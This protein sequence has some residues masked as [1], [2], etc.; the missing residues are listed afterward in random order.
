MKRFIKNT[1]HG[2]LHFGSLGGR[3]SRQTFCDICKGFLL[4]AL[5]GIFACAWRNT[6]AA[7]Y[8]RDLL[9]ISEEGCWVICILFE[10]FLLCA[11]ATAALRRWQDLDI[12]IPPNDSLGRLITRA[13]F[14]QVLTTEEG[15]TEPNQHGPAPADNPVPLINEQDLKEDILQKLFVDLDSETDGLK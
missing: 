5:F 11:F 13:R 10:L 8:L 2:L 15:S 7:L 1:L 9:V 14:W 3:D 4:L 12:R 6:L